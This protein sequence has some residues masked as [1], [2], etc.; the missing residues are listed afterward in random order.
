MIEIQE[1]DWM[2][3][4]D[5]ATKLKAP[6]VKRAFGIHHTAI[7]ED[8]IKEQIIPQP[9]ERQQRGDKRTNSHFWLVSELRKDFIGD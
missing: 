8:L 1:P 5:G 4:M 2:K 3:D 7:I 6:E 9:M